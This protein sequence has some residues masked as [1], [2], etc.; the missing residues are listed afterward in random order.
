MKRLGVIGVS[1]AWLLVQA[2]ATYAQMQ[3]YDAE[4]V[5][6]RGNS[7]V[8]ACTKVI[9][10]G[11]WRGK[12]LAWAY[13]NR[14]Y[15]YID[16]NNLDAAIAD[17]TKA[18]SLK[19]DGRYYSSRGISYLKQNKYDEAI[20]DLNKALELEPGDAISLEN[21]A[22]AYGSKGMY[23]RA[24][25]D[26]ESAVDFGGDTSSLWN[27]YGYDLFM[28][29]RYNE[30]LKYFDRSIK[31]DPTNAEAYGNRGQLKFKLGDF[32]GADADATRSREL[33][34]QRNAKISQ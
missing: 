14:G 8:I 25:P 2:S 29:G 6:E 4:C 3:P 24:I 12:N 9:N 19:S 26:Y 17:Y 33:V 23:E 34:D 13:G 32:E 20:V 10:Y 21:R 18:I 28:L 1:S 7:Q 30:A 5:N 15:A 11:Y 16:L 22:A 31:I 27:N